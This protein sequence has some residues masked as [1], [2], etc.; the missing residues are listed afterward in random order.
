M[1]TQTFASM[2]A[3]SAVTSGLTATQASGC[4]ASNNSDGTATLTFPD[5][6]ASAIS[7]T[8]TLQSGLKGYANAKQ[9]AIMNGGISVTVASGVSVECST[10]PAAIG[11]LQGAATIAASSPS[12]TFN[13]VPSTGTPITLT[14][15]QIT[16]MFT[17]VSAF[18]QSTFTTLAG[19][20]NAINA[21]TITTKAQ[22]D[23]PPSPIPAWPVNS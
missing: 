21:G 6:L 5:S 11:L 14:A 18:I 9:S 19:V 22:V 3:L 17:G 12:T 7:G 13:W 23:T 16:A 8:S 15:A 2:D 1:G 20:I 4:I 10:T